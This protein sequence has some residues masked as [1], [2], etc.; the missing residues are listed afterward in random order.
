MIAI[1]AIAAL[2]AVVR[3]SAVRDACVTTER[4]A[5]VNIP[6]SPDSKSTEVG[7]GDAVFVEGRFV[8]SILTVRNGRRYVANASED[9]TAF[10]RAL[11]IR[12]SRGNHR[13]DVWPI[14]ARATLPIGYVRIRCFSTL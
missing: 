8:G 6:I 4:W 13:G 9:S 12:T 2:D 1:A 14:G 11:G 3:L 7:R 10:L 5:D